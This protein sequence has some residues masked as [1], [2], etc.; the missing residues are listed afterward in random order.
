[1]ENMLYML[2][3][4]QQQQQQ[5]QQ[6]SMQR[7]QES[8]LKAIDKLV[9]KEAPRNSGPSSSLHGRRATITWSLLGHQLI[10]ALRARFMVEWALQTS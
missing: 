9:T 3:Q 6:E 5:Q 7:Q 8:L 10:V 2:I 4:A 1:M